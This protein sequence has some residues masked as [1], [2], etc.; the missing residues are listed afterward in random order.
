MMPVCR[1]EGVKIAEVFWDVTPRVWWVGSN[2]LEESAVTIFK[3]ADVLCLEDGVSS[4]EV[5]VPT[6]PILHPYTVFSILVLEVFVNKIRPVSLRRD[7]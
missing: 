3:V 1:S 2:I 6:C 5:L 4:S 7:P